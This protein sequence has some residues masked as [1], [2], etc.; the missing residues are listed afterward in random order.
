MASIP[1]SA[2]RLG[3]HLSFW[4]LQ[5]ALGT[6]AEIQGQRIKSALLADGKKALVFVEYGTKHDPGFEWIY[7]DPNI[8]DSQIIWARRV[9]PESD[10]ALIKR[11]R[12][13]SIWVL[14]PDVHPEALIRIP[15]GN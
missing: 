12:S 6:P 9:N 5:W 3:W 11:F 14:R 8:P 4:P 15:L 2:H 7:N 13:R 10:A 1:A